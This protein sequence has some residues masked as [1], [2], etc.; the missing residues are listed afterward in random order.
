MLLRFDNPFIRAGG[1]GGGCIL[2]AFMKFVE[3][4]FISG[5]EV[6]PFVITIDDCISSLVGDLD[7][8]FCFFR[9]LY[10][11]LNEKD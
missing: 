3:N 6:M 5:Q 11:A 10:A 8:R 2:M 1:A 9:S 7:S 4:M